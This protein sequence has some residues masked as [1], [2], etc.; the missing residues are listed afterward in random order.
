[1]R[2]EDYIDCILRYQGIGYAAQNWEKLPATW[3]D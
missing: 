2:F 1:M 3:S